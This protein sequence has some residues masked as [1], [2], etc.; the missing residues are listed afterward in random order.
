MDFGEPVLYWVTTV[1]LSLSLTACV[2]VFVFL[3][4]CQCVYLCV[5]GCIFVPPRALTYSQ[6]GR[7]FALGWS[8]SLEMR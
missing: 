7:W 3:S 8:G 1:S 2:C 6:A 4:V 5:H